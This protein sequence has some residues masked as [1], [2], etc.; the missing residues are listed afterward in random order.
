MTG[1]QLTVTGT[2]FGAGATITLSYSGGVI[3]VD[4]GTITASPTGGFTALVTILAAQPGSSNLTAIGSDS[5]SDAA[6]SAYTLTN[7]NDYVSASLTASSSGTATVNQ[8]ATMGVSVTIQNAPDA[9]GQV[10]ISDLSAPATGVSAL[11][12]SGTKYYDVLVTNMPG[13]ASATVCIT[14]ASI[15]SSTE[16]YW[17]PGGSSFVAIASTFDAP[18]T[19]CT[20]APIS[21]SQLGGTNFAT[22]TPSTSGGG[23]G[24]LYVSQTVTLTPGTGG[25]PVSFSLSGCSVVPSVVQGDGHA[26]HIA[27]YPGCRVT[28]SAISE[29][30]D[31]RSVFAGGNETIEFTSCIGL[32]CSSSLNATYY[33]QVFQNLS[34]FVTGGA[35]GSSAPV[36]AGLQFGSAFTVTL[37]T[38]PEGYW[39]DATGGVALPSLLPG[40]GTQERWE[41]A[42]FS[43]GILSADVPHSLMLVYAHQFSVALAVSPQGAGT[44]TPSGESWLN[45]SSTVTISAAASSGYYFSGWVSSSGSIALTNRS[46]PS[47]TFV[48]DGPGTLTATFAPSSTPL[49][50]PPLPRPSLAPA[51]RRP[52]HPRPLL[53][54]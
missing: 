26:H 3:V 30:A 17:A 11:S 39:L 5:P 21:L 54:R 23:E 12:L 24:S 13:A 7:V 48:A 19:L 1:A 41:L 28:V 53:A 15:T 43:A 27:A 46:A 22:G 31:T 10:T 4:S 33:V 40:S 37:T 18:D 2:N 9:S 8:T 45:A 52:R 49:Q 42:S 16:L 20:S 6:S 36:V 51:L 14:D 50:P 35:Q 32:G 34:Y 38:T 47:T 25:G 29:G 44:T